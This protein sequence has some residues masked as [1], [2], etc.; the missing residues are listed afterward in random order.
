M[1]QDT[2]P[3]NSKEKLKFLFKF[4]QQNKQ[5]ARLV[6]FISIL[7][8]TVFL[9]V[10]LVLPFKDKLLNLL[11]P[12][13]KSQA[14][15]CTGSSIVPADKAGFIYTG[16]D[17]TQE[18]SALGTSLYYTY[19]L[20]LGPKK[21]I[22]MIGKYTQNQLDPLGLKLLADGNLSNSEFKGLWGQSPIGW[23][24]MTAGKSGTT[25]IET[26][27]ENLVN[28]QT[29]VKVANH[30]SPSGTQISQA[31]KK[32]VV[33]GQLIIFGSWVKTSDPNGVK[34][35]LQNS[36]DP[37]EE[38]GVI[39]TKIEAN[40]WNFVVGY[41][42]IPKG[43]TNTQ[44]VLRV[45][46]LDTTAWF[47]G[48]VAAVL[49]TESNKA[50][51]DLVS[52]RCGAAW[53]VDNDPGWDQT[54][55]N[56]HQAP[57]SPEIYALLYNQY[58]TLI[59]AVD[60]SATVLPGALVGAPTPF[61]GQDVYTPKLFLDQWR[62]AYN[63]FFGTEPPVDALSI[64]YTAMDSTSWTNSAGLED[65]MSELRAYIN[66]IPQWKDKPIWITKLGVSQSAPNGGADFTKTALSYL[67]T[68]NLKIDKWFWFDTCGYKSQLGSLFTANNKICN[69][70][71]KLTLL[72]EAYFA[73][74]ITPK[75]TIPVTTTPVASSSAATVTPTPT[76]APVATLTP[77]A[78]AEPT[79]TTVSI[80]QEN[81]SSSGTT[82]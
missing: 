32:D 71:M 4:G 79:P 42:K 33:E 36:K 75:P 78:A 59:K 18:M 40:S 46:S 24:L 5:N 56:F 29:S 9:L 65:Y 55:T 19:D 50:I 27:R 21:A 22:Y 10:S 41:A 20:S 2:A 30:K 25:N 74:N 54:Y 64:S 1:N 66:Q 11:Y 38:L 35:L 68:N 6:V 28:D 17:L 37:F 26:V 70:P 39:D 67:Q 81:A 82:P 73:K 57:L 61:E 45:T 53:I 51:T 7:C 63:R 58:Y 60:P 3:D 15:A 31:I 69:W 80:D 8:F 23:N 12:K 62:A 47:D 49:T 13:P 43:V 34:V 44:L 14:T 76:V 77:S 52:E 72:G 16:G 48:A